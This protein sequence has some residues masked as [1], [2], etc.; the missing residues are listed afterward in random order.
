M[1]LWAG[2][3]PRHVITCRSGEHVKFHCRLIIYSNRPYQK[4]KV[5]WDNGIIGKK[6]VFKALNYSKRE[7]KWPPQDSN[8]Q[9]FGTVRRSKPNALPLRQVAI[10]LNQTLDSIAR[11]LRKFKLR[12]F[13]FSNLNIKKFPVKVPVQYTT[14][15]ARSE[16]SPKAHERGIVYFFKLTS[17]MTLAFF[18]YVPSWQYHGR[19]QPFT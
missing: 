13:H 5:A 12:A 18:G 1:N 6:K 3:D 10:K 17:Q 8:L 9:P 4:K 2:R 14:L 11:I 16:W 19:E 7:K 15:Y